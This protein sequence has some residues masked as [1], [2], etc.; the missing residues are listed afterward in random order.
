MRKD[1]VISFVFAGVLAAGFLWNVL[2]PSR[3]Y[4]ERENR[5]LRNS[6]HL[7]RPALFRTVRQRFRNLYHG[8]V[9]DAG[10]L[11]CSQNFGG[12][13]DAPTDNGRVYFGENQRLFEIPEAADAGLQQSNCRA[14][15]AFLEKVT[16]MDPTIRTGGDACPHRHHDLK[17]G[18]AGLCAGS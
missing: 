5:Y 7:R 18:V 17:R 13:G 3:S 2:T 4:S 14:V 11:G 6:P 15:A 8:S 12:A 1:K 10:Q 16:Q 9:P